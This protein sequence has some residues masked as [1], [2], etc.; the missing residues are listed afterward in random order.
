MGRGRRIWIREF[1]ND[2]ELHF[3]D[4][5]RWKIGRKISEKSFDTPRKHSST[6]YR[7]G[8]SQAVYECEQIE[9]PSVGEEAILKIRMQ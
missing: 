1:F 6:G 2:R 4:G 9:G 5:T 7:Q 8:E 3:K